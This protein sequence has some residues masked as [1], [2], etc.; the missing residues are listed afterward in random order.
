MGVIGPDT[1]GRLAAVTVDDELF[2]GPSPDQ[3]VTTAEPVRVGRF[4]LIRR[5]GAGGMGAVYAAYDELLDRKVALKIMHP[6]RS[7]SMGQRQRTLVE[8]RALARVTHPSIV[9]V[10]EVGEADSNIYISME[11][12]DGKTLSDWC[13]D[14][15]RTWRE[16]LDMYLQAGAGLHAAHQAGIVH[17]EPKRSQSSS[18]NG[19]CDARSETLRNEVNS[20]TQTDFP[21][22]SKARFDQLAALQPWAVQSAPRCSTSR[23]LK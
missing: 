23:A 11:F 2:E 4:P 14:A 18:R 16:I 19:S 13:G 20:R 9:T 17:R 10:Y 6:E 12:I 5:L 8:A 7:G 15:R 21:T 22:I 3:R 1:K